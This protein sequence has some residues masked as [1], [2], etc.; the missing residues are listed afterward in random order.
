[1]IMTK[2]HGILAAVALL[3]AASGARAA[4]P[5]RTEDT[6]TQGT[7]N[8]QLEL[9]AQLARQREDGVTLRDV[10][11]AAVL[12][13][14]VLPN[15]DLQLGQAY[16]RSVTD[17]GATREVTDGALDTAIDVKWRFY[18]RGTLSLALKPGITLP[19][20]D[21]ARGLGAGEVTW[22]G[23]LIGSY[24]PGPLAIHADLGYRRNRN[25]LG[26]R[27]SLSHVSAAVL[28][29]ASPRL[30][31]VADASADS[32]PLPAAYGTLRYSVIGFIYSPSADL[33]LDAGVQFRLDGAADDHSL[34]LG[35]TLRW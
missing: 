16:L 6:A 31:L 3:L 14:G 9:S 18:E 2:A 21:D 28:Y 32:N 13:Y 12:S 19:T 7:G 17:D 22:G 5:L 15:V 8:Y 30:K 29:T 20:G 11:P 33:D 35:L 25:T 10:Q 1:M 23:L 24:Q 34:L 27:E 4:H 26:S